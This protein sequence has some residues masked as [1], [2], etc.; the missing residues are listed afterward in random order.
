MTQDNHGLPQTVGNHGQTDPIFGNSGGSGSE[1]AG[2]ET[3]ATRIMEIVTKFI[4]KKWRYSL[5]SD[6][7]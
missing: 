5:K 1:V 4:F 3:R 2:L 7:P 6:L